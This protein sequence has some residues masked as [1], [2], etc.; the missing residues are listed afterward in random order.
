[1]KAALALPAM[2]KCA[3][4]LK[5]GGPDVVA[6]VEAPLTDLVA[7]LGPTQVLLRNAFAGVNF[8]DTYY[9]T[10]LYPKPGGYPYTSGEEGSGAV[11]KV[12]DAV[13]PSVWLGKRVAFFRAVTGSYATYSVADLDDLF[14]VPDGVADD[15][16]AAVM[17][18]GCTAHYL[19]HDC[20][21]CAPGTTVV[22]H[23]AAGGTGLLISQMAKQRGA[24]VVGIVGNAEKAALAKTLG[25]CDHVVN[26]MES[27]A[28]PAAVKALVPGG[29]HAVFDGVGRTTFEGSLSVLRRRGA[30]VSF[31]NAS[32]AVAPVAPLTLTKHGSVTLQRPKLG[33][34]AC[35]EDGEI[36]RR[37]ADVFAGIAAGWLKVHVGATLPLA[38]AAAAHEL[39]ESKAS[40]GKILVDCRESAA[41]PA[42]L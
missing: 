34:F 12:G 23:A 24:T 27:A 21:P 38:S 7:A 28:W 8:I 16:A 41:G 4:V 29:A 32:G 25:K 19:T 3:R 11:V 1:M 13:D 42:S 14:P 6:V 30:M 9:R 31:G 17:L 2:Y 18:Q 39:I 35:K 40:F 33:D 37:V 26:Y 36:A 22:V 10:G 5:A 20:F 15:V